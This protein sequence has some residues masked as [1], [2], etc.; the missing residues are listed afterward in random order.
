MVLIE[1]A[2][3]IVFGRETALAFG[4]LYSKAKAKSLRGREM[5]LIV[6][7]QWEPGFLWASLPRAVLFEL[8][9]RARYVMQ[10]TLARF[11]IPAAG[12]LLGAILALG[13]LLFISVYSYISYMSFNIDNAFVTIPWL[14]FL[15]V[16]AFMGGG[17][18]F[19]V[20]WRVMMAIG[21]RPLWVFRLR[22]GE[23]GQPGTLEA[24]VPRTLLEQTMMVG[25]GK[26][27][28]RRPMVYR[29]SY[30]KK[31]REQPHVRR[32]FRMK[33][34]RWEKLQLAS[35]VVLALSLVGAI[36]FWVLASQQQ[37]TGV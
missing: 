14:N 31:V 32:L 10:Q 25:E 24:L 37:P 3:T 33:G 36:L 8:D 5:V 30:M 4:K 16:A 13:T 20:G 28:V 27:E 34:T 1:A 11:I 18:G 22:K 23:A 9:R 7:D 21:T 15:G 19:A 29:G 6:H 26:A 35:L 17:L 12:A 2:K